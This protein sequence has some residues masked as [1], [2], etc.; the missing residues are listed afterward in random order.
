[1]IENKVDKI[2]CAWSNADP[3]LT[4]YHDEEWGDIRHDDKVHYEYLIMEVMQCGLSWSLMLKKRD[5]FRKCFANFDF[6]KVALFT[7]DDI[8]SI[9]K[10]KGMIKS[11]PKITAV[12]NN[13]KVFLDIRKEYG[14][15]DKYIWSFTCNK[16]IIFKSKQ[17][18]TESKY[19]EYLSKDLR[20][21]GCKFLGPT[22]LHSH[23]QAVGI[24][25]SH[26]PNCWKYKKFFD[27]KPKNILYV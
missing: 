9:L 7:E 13:T 12:I 17:R 1:M 6:N 16:I 23:L 14:S 5:I 3:L 4:K 20:K 19:S 21:K 24:I 10:T 15:F 22:V 27:N 11:Y 8:K 18:I 26:H 2:R 25:F